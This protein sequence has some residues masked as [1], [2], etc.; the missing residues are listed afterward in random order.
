[1][2]SVLKN[3]RKRKVQE[4]TYQQIK[5]A[6]KSLANREDI[7]ITKADKGNAVVI[8]DVSDYIN[9]ANR[10]LNSTKFYKKITKDRTVM[11]IIK[12]NKTIKVIKELKI[13]H[14]LNKRNARNL[15]FGETKIQ[16]CFQNSLKK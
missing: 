6:L 15:K 14:L 10:Q 1:M 11:H 16:N 8:V 7:I 2:V 12:V 5:K 13:C 4:V 3:K 9:E